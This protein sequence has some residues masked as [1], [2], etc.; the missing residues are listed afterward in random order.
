VF[1]N[2]AEQPDNEHT[3]FSSPDGRTTLE[4]VVDQNPQKRT[5]SQVYR[6]WIAEFEKKS[7]IGYKILK[8]NWFVISGDANGRGYYTKC[9]GRDNKLFIMS[10][11]Y[12][13]EGDAISEE[14]VTTMSRSFNGRK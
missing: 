12:D 10:M 1:P 4:L 6:D 3:K 8:G 11:E 13:E 2:P 7:T 5:V 9:V 14:T